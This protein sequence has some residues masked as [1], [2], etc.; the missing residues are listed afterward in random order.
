MVERHIEEEKHMSDGKIMWTKSWIFEYVPLILVKQCHISPICHY[1][2]TRIENC[3]SGDGGSYC[4]TVNQSTE[5][6]FFPTS[7][8]PPPLQAMKRKS[9]VQ[10]SWFPTFGRCDGRWEVV[11]TDVVGLVSLSRYR[12]GAER[13]GPLWPWEPQPGAA[14]EQATGIERVRKAVCIE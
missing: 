12:F 14:N 9:K 8:F 5:L 2:I 3:K 11:V 10:W 1:F 4:F 6:F 7:L 13:M